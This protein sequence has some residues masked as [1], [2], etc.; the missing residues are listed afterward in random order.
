MLTFHLDGRDLP[1][2]TEGLDAATEQ[3][4]GHPDFRGFV[5]LDHDSVRHQI[6]IL[7]LWDGDGLEASHPLFKRATEIIASCAD[8]AM[9]ST[10]YDVLRLVPGTVLN[11]DAFGQVV[12]I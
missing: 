8:L 11:E 3:L 4:A 10:T 5:C 2:L 12:T 1:K 9:N 7:S 6:I